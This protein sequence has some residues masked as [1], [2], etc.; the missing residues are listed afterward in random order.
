MEEK[1]QAMMFAMKLIGL[2]RRSV[3]E[4]EERLKQ[5][6]YQEDIIATTIDELK[7]FRYLDDEAFAEAFIRDRINLRPCG[8]RMMGRE[9]RAK[10]VSSG[11][12]EEKLASLFD[13]QTEIELARRLV[14]KKMK[15]VKDG[16]DKNKTRRKLSAFLASRGFSF[17]IISQALKNKLE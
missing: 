7:K 6:D 9:L 1:N 10:G 13:E 11:I 2:R 16:A 12:I 3:F 5:K 8:K 14:S 15:V 17:D 4:I